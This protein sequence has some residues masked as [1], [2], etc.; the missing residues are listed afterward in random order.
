MAFF[1]RPFSSVRL[2]FL[3]ALIYV[4]GIQIFLQ[5]FHIK[6]KT[7]LFFSIAGL[8]IN[9]IMTEGCAFFGVF[10]EDH[11]TR[12]FLLTGYPFFGIGL[13]LRENKEKAV[14]IK[15]YVC[16]FS[17]AVGIVITLL[18]NSYVK[19]L[20]LYAGSIIIAFA[21]FVLAMKA[22][23]VRY[24]DCLVKLSSTSLGIYIFHRP[25]TTFIN[26]ILEAIS[27]KEGS[28]AAGIILPILVCFVTA[29]FSLLLISLKNYLIKKRIINR[30][31]N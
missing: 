3:L 27:I 31:V 6:S 26:Q 18:S 28:V 22:E 14:L 10:F 19:S 9:V 1:N 16:I 8:I 30:C 4:Y 20:C 29:I 15:P 21:S 17:I 13:F 11:L 25:I 2:W 5:K 24:P 23:G 7:I 12:N